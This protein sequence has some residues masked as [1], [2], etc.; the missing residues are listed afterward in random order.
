MTA[1]KPK[2]AGLTQLSLTAVQLLKKPIWFLFAENPYKDAIKG[3][4][5]TSDS[6]DDKFYSNDPYS[7]TIFEIV[8]VYMLKKINVSKACMNLGASLYFY[9]FTANQIFSQ[10]IKKPA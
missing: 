2:N 9:L 10:F 5:L 4:V 7:C 8:V 3:T 6:L 1:I